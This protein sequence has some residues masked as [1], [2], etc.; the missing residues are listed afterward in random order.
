M[1]FSFNVAG[2]TLP[3]ALRSVHLRNLRGVPAPARLTTRRSK[4][5]PS[6][7]ATISDD[8]N[9]DDDHDDDNDE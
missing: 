1:V 9:D 7:L 8:D 6:K 2:A 4:L 5:F 3:S